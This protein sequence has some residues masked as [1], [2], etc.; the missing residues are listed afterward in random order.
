MNG[1]RVLRWGVSS[2]DA[3]PLRLETPV[4]RPTFAPWAAYLPILFS[5]QTPGALTAALV[6]ASGTLV[7][8]DVEVWH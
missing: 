6:R 1:C 4:P 2:H 8:Q 7:R 5:R 3:I